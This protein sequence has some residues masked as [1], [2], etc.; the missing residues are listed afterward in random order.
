MKS[1]G[2]VV[3][4]K[5]DLDIA[6]LSQELSHFAD[7]IRPGD[8]VFLYFSGYGIQAKPGYAAA[9]QEETQNWLVPTSF[10]PINRHRVSR[11]RY[12]VSL[13]TEVW[14]EHK[15]GPGIIVID[16]NR[17]CAKLESRATDIGL[18]A[19]DPRT[20]DT[21]IAYAAEPEQIAADPTDGAM[22]LFTSNLISAVREPGL[23]PTQIFNRVQNRS[24]TRV[25]WKTDALLYLA[26]D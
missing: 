5:T 26:C 15:A 24:Q 22:N 1:L 21:L 20:E 7:S 6:A 9:E 19:E 18:I 3:T 11:R 4:V 25:K 16:A 2:V 17:I 8:I 13:V 23:T 14:N 12:A 10:D